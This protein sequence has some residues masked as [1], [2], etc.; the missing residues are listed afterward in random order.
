MGAGNGRKGL[1]FCHQGIV[2]DVEA[3]QIEVIHQGGLLVEERLAVDKDAK[4]GRLDRFR[5]V[6]RQ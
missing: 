1:G 4:G 2:N 5:F 3:G 6:A